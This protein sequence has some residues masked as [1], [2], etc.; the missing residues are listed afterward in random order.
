MTRDWCSRGSFNNGK[1]YRYFHIAVTV[2]LLTE[3]GTFLHAQVPG[4]S[5]HLVGANKQPRAVPTFTGSM[6]ELPSSAPTPLSRGRVCMACTAS[7]LAEC[8]DSRIR[9]AKAQSSVLLMGVKRLE[10]AISSLSKKLHSPLWWLKYKIIFNQNHV[11]T[12][13][14]AP[15]LPCSPS[16]H[17][18][19]LLDTAG[20]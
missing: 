1:V 2:L 9:T 17:C 10:Q 7:A 13:I 12:T 3:V 14:M 6:C 19:I 15:G 4:A 18:P 20:Y 5:S 8:E 16:L 11:S